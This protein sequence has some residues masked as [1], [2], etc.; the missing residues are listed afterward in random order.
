MSNLRVPRFDGRSRVMLAAA[1]LFP[2]VF[3]LILLL[4]DIGRRDLEALSIFWAASML[5]S[6]AA[7]YLAFAAA[8]LLRWVNQGLTD[9]DRASLALVTR[10]TVGAMCLLLA[11]ATLMLFRYEI[12]PLSRSTNDAYLKHDRWTGEVT[13]ELARSRMMTFQRPTPI[14]N[15]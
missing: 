5:L 8:K 7:T 1:L 12:V 4:L 3:V 2:L 10:I 14:G 11:I 15:L 9:S 6:V 13:T